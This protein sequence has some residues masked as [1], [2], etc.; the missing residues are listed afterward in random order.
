MNATSAAPAQYQVEHFGPSEGWGDLVYQRASGATM[1]K[2][3]LGAKLGLTGM[4]VSLS[5]MAPGRMSNGCWGSSEPSMLGLPTSWDLTLARWKAG[6][7]P[8]WRRLMASSATWPSDALCKQGKP[9]P[10]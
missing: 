7:W 6:P 4:E 9:Q 3:F 2:G 1:G 8:P 10:I 5:S